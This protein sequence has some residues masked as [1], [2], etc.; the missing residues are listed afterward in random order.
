MA[1]EKETKPKE[2]RELRALDDLEASPHASALRALAKELLVPLSQAAD[3]RRALDEADVNAK[4]EARG[5]SVD[6]D[7]TAT[8][9]LDVLRR[10]ASTE[11]ERAI[12]S[13][14]AAMALSETTSGEGE[15]EATAASLIH[16]A[17]TTSFDASM[18]VDRAFGDRA[19]DVWRAIAD[20][21]R[22][23]DGGRLPSASRGEIAVAS[24]ILASSTSKA[25]QVA[26][27][28]C[29]PE[30]PLLARILSE[31]NGKVEETRIDG[32]LTTAPR[33]P[34]ATFFLAISGILLI[35]TVARLFGRFA[36]SYRRP[37]ELWISERGIRVK[38]KTQLLGRTLRERE[39][40]IDKGGLARAV[41]EVR[42]PS[43][44]VYLGLLFLAVGS[45]VGVG[46]LVDGVRAASPS[47]LGTGLLVVAGGIALE[48]LLASV[49][50]GATGTCRVF[51]LP[52][53]GAKVC[54][55]TKDASRA[56]AALAKLK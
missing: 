5:L 27:A 29:S 44:G 53:R 55:A 43:L 3:G 46:A 13:A 25:A 2:R 9:A 30:D 18:L 51:F 16:L 15:I 39:I 37:A 48:L 7:T 19:G 36:L 41:R 11:D 50:P 33:S 1:D 45:Y 10:G 26:R 47:L 21:I 28:A 49:G 42:F 24:A 38:T 8:A 23:W 6:D 4:I 17:S 34:V 32:E 20:R 56:D 12:A 35:V 22:R 31:P 54:V 52:R 14:L 40:R